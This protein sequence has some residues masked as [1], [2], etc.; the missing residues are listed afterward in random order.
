MIRSR[1]YIVCLIACL[2]I[3][4]NNCA[5]G[6]RPVASADGGVEQG[7]IHYGFG[8]QVGASM[9][10]NS[11][12][13]ILGIAGYYRFSWDDGHNNSV[14]LGAQGRYH[15]GSGTV[16]P[17]WAGAEAK[18]IHATDHYEEEFFKEFSNGKFPSTNGF[19]LGLLGGY[20][21]P[22]GAVDLNIF[23]AFNITH[24]GDYKVMDL[25]FDESGNSWQV[26]V[27]LEAPLPLMRK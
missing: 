27:G 11:D 12:V 9:K 7:S 21:I 15:L 4:L 26:R 23:A 22:A 17:W 10:L 6:P 1:L 20:I 3:M 14:S 8:G 16:R 18:W 19:S 5:R 13:S 2:A 25:V 24:F